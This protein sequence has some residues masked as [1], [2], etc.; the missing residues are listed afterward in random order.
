[1]PVD[2]YLESSSLLELNFLRLH[3]MGKEMEPPKKGGAGEMT[4]Q[5][6]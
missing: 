1:M 2:F 6:L 5:V 3:E 4:A